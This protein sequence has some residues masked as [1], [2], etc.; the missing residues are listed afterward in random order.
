MPLP[1]AEQ[2]GL[3]KPDTKRLVHAVLEVVGSTRTLD[4]AAALIAEACQSGR[5]QPAEILRALGEH[6]RL[7]FQP[8]A[9]PQAAKNLLRQSLPGKTRHDDLAGRLEGAGPDA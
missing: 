7:C 3:L 9:V 2:L 5:V 8:T 1:A 4:D 6:R